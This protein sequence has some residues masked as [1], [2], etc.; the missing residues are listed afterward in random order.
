MYECV[1]QCGYV[2]VSSG[3]CSGPKRVSD[4]QELEFQVV[5]STGIGSGPLQE[6]HPLTTEPSSTSIL[7][8]LYFCSSI[9]NTDQDE[10]VS[11]CFLEARK[12]V[13]FPS[14]L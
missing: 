14:H 2:L 13:S 10:I 11:C 8:S 12:C 6:Q 4:P 3:A 9:L 1:S 5:V 7:E